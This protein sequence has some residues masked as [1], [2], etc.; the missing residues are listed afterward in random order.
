MT[1]HG[2]EE[3]PGIAVTSYS[4]TLKE[5]GGFVGDRANGRAFFGILDEL[6]KPLCDA[7][8]DPFGGVATD[9]LSNDDIDDAWRTGDAF[10]AGLIHT[11]IE[12]FAQRLA[13]VVRA[14]QRADRNWAKVRRIVVGGGLR[15]S[16]IG[17]IAIGRTTAILRLEGGAVDLVPIEEDPDEAA[18]LGGLRLIEADR[19]RNSSRM[20]AVDIGGSS[21][22]A[23]LIHFDPERPHDLS[24]A[25]V[26]AL[27]QWKYGEES[28]QPSRDE[29]IERL[30]G[31][32]DGLEKRADRPLAQFITVACPGRIHE[33]GDIREGAQN[34]PGNWEADDFNLPGA[35]SGSLDGDYEIILHNDAVV[36]GLSEAARM[37]DVENWA[38]VTIGTGLGN[39][40]YANRSSASRDD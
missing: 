30:A 35:L 37:G 26:D 13:G 6:R 31:M 12:E 8:T 23:G 40:A 7:G 14:Y 28:K 34:L 22:R 38:V 16:R 2:S 36:Q 3:L 4:L 17:E 39:A 1:A 19:L 29:A 9:D 27:D 33:N 32:L 18:L 11:S 24:K 5:G 10:A 15:D 21:I 25:S 20:L